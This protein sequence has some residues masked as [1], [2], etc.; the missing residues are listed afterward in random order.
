MIVDHK[1]SFIT[2]RKFPRL[3]MLK[4]S[5]HFATGRRFEVKSKAQNGLKRRCQ[6]ITI[7]YIPE[8]E[9]KPRSIFVPISLDKRSQLRK[10]VR[11]HLPLACCFDLCHLQWL[12]SMDSNSARFVGSRMGLLCGERL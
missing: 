6:G 7:S 12:E 1:G 9:S 5:L 4:V 11:M 2:Q 8:T 3:A 10:P